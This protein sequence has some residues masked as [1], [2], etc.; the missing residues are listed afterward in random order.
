MD[1]GTNG[2][3]G[4]IDNERFM[5]KMLYVCMGHTERERGG[6]IVVIYQ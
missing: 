6:E 5:F 4:D 2:R 3:Q 1:D